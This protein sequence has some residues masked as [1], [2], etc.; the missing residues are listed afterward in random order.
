MWTGQGIDIKFA[1]IY[2]A[3]R[4]NGLLCSSILYI[5]SPFI[6]VYVRLLKMPILP[7]LFNITPSYMVCQVSSLFIHELLSFG[8]EIGVKVG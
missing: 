8:V 7:G 2:K 3:G 1:G 4:K 5:L 6:V